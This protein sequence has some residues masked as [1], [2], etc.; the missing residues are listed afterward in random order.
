MS[1]NKSSTPK[2]EDCFGAPTS[3]VRHAH[4]SIRAE[5][6][7][8]NVDGTWDIMIAAQEL[9]EQQHNMIKE[10]FPHLAEKVYELLNVELLLGSVVE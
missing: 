6:C 9:S 7:K 3:P 4:I 8:K 1:V 5:D 10:M 2:I